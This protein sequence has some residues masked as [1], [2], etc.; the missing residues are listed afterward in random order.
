VKIK[1]KLI[2]V[3]VLV[4]VGV[5]AVLVT[6][7]GHDDPPATGLDTAA[8]RACQDFADGYPRAHSKAAR[9]TLADRVMRSSG[10]TGNDVIS[11]RAAEM[12]RSAADGGAKWK[13][14]ADALTGA[15]HDAGWTAG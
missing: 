9:L 14:S 8:R 6:R 15:C 13:S 10:D 1:P 5:G 12:G 7:A 4:A 2:V 3:L 11:K